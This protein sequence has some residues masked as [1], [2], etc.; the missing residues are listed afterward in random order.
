ME[1]ITAAGHYSVVAK[2]GRRRLGATMNH[3]TRHIEH[4]D[5]PL[6]LCLSKC[7]YKIPVFVFLHAAHLHCTRPIELLDVKDMHALQMLMTTNICQCIV[8]SLCGHHILYML[9]KNG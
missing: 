4:K 7:V 8:K 2:A 9:C 3:D 5:L 6:M 1:S